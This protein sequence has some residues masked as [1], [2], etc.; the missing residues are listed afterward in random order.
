MYIIELF[1]AYIVYAP[2]L[3]IGVCSLFFG[4]LVLLLI[5]F[6]ALR[7]RSRRKRGH[8][9]YVVS[10]KE[11]LPYYK[12][13]WGEIEVANYLN[14]LSNEYVVI[15]DVMIETNN[16]TSQIDHI[17]VSPYGIFVI[18][19]KNYS[20][21]LYGEEYESYVPY[22]CG[23][24]QYSIYNPLKQNRS[25]VY[26]LMNALDIPN[27]NVFVPILA[28]SD[29]C[30][31]HMQ[32]KVDIVPFAYVC[33]AIDQYKY[34]MFSRREVLSIAQRISDLNIQNAE[35]REKHV[36]RVRLSNECPF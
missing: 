20:G 3:L 8:S 25:H 10:N 22:V 18:E 15:N 23:S 31:S 9:P 34:K 2:P 13:R 5:I 17:V 6:G 14:S 21:I 28:I 7:R 29:D 30:E 11:A 4:P 16:R 32:A 35:E 1:E 12:G 33:D 27:R 24:N 36:E 19:T 26:T